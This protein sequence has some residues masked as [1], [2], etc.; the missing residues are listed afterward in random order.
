MKQ[1]RQLLR[2]GGQFA[3][4][5]FREYA[6]RRARDSFREHKDV[7]DAKAITELLEKGKKELQSMKVRFGPGALS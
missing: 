5:N 3:N 1:Y 6:K 4:Y 7:Q 2:E